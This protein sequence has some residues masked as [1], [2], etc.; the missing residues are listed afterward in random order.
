MG[1]GRPRLELDRLWPGLVA[2]ARGASWPEAVAACSVSLNTLKRRWAEQ[3][4]GVFRDRVPRK[5]AL[6]LEHRVEIESGLAA[7]RKQVEI[8]RRIGK[9]PST[10][11][12]EIAG[13]GGPVRYRAIRAQH[14]ADDAAARPKQGWTEERSW[15][16]AEVV[17]WLLTKKWSPEAIACRLRREHPDESQWWVSHEAIYQ[18][19]YVQARPEL[20]KQLI[21]ALHSR[22]AR[23][24]PRNPPRVG[25]SKIVGMVNIAERPPEA[26]DRT[27]PG[28]WEGDLIIGKGGSS[29]AATLVER[30]SR[31][32]LL[33][34]L[35]S[36][37]ADHV[38]ERISIALGQLPA[39]LARS[40]TWDQG[41]EMA[42]HQAFSESTGIKVYFCD[43]HSPW[44]RP[45]NEHWNGKVRWFLPKGV[46][47]S[48]YSQEQL[49]DIAAIINGRPREMF[50]WDTAAERF[51]QLI[52]TTP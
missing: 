33:I 9:H 6:T 38:A 12:R 28:H 36:K 11:C 47:L 20:R 13:N 25:S 5:N 40:L 21:A 18:A 27:V 2:R 46:D 29:A 23:R 32:G 17:E 8:A 45:S 41:T 19:I 42:A 1:R 44:Q 35:D 48:T 39:V 50:K 22:R 24:L 3:G 43:P 4:C 15:L 7:G 37:N 16:W 26:D 31:F 30:T 52:A 34:K 49:D 10:V 51:E 14:H